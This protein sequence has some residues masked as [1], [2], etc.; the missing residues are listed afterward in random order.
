[1]IKF[2]M[3]CPQCGK[4]YKLDEQKCQVCKVQLKVVFDNK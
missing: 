4:L 3:R 1:M 2:C